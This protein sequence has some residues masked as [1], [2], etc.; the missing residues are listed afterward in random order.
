VVRRIELPTFR[1][2]GLRSTM[3][4][5]SQR[6]L[7]LLSDLPYT[8]IDARTR[9]CMRLEMRLPRWI[10]RRYAFFVAG[11]DVKRHDLRAGPGDRTPTARRLPEGLLAEHHLTEP[12]KPGDH[13]QRCRTHGLPGP[14]AQLLQQADTSPWIRTINLVLDQVLQLPLRLAT[15]A[16]RSS[17]AA[18]ASRITSRHS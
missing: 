16:R 1:F 3:Q 7:W 2:S 14:L 11:L 8:P 15:A 9:P 18:C 12:S 6:S 13:L 5:R 17:V 4:N 10:L